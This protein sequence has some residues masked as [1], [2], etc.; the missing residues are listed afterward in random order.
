MSSALQLLLL[1]LVVVAGF[2]AGC[3]PTG[4]E[5]AAPAAAGQNNA[6]LDRRPL[7]TFA[8]RQP[9][10]IEIAERY[11]QPLLDY[12]TEH[13]P[14][15]F[16]T[17]FS[18][19][20]E[21]TVGMLEQRMAE[22]SHLGVLSYLE[23]HRQFGALPLVRPLNR[24]REPISRSVFVVRDDG[25]LQVLADL[26]G[27]SL[28]LGA[29]HSTLSNLIPR[30]ELVRAGVSLET[31][32]RVGHLANDEEV[33]AG[34]LA[35]R[36]DAGAVADVVADRYVDKGLRV[37][38]TS[39]PIPSA[40]LAIRNDLPQHVSDAVREALLK[41]DFEEPDGRQGW[42]EEFRYGFAPATDSDYQSVRDIVESSLTRC[43]SSCHEELGIE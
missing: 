34:V 37:F 9:I 8:F 40:P 25:P 23:S 18:R 41:V 33:V 22:I 12:L 15:R 7:V 5:R 4:G 32:E 36:F 16:R 3:N 30:H 10:G 6:L 42:D 28:A 19:D 13:T 35:G 2:L 27:R 26:E 1:R 38:H 39:G 17:V 31:L 29:F 21:R 24:D 14:Y 43:A 20:S 11:R